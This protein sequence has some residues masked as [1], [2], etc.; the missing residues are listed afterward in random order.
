LNVEPILD[1]SSQRVDPG[2]QGREPKRMDLL[3]EPG[4]LLAEVAKVV[5]PGRMGPM[6]RGHGPGGI[7]QRPM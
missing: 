1:P 2:D 6:G 5:V 7:S 4:D 3:L